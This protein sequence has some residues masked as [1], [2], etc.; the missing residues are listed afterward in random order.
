MPTFDHLF[1]SAHEGNNESIWEVN[2]DGWG[3]PIGAWNTFMFL[4]T[5]WK[6]FN[7]PSHNLV[8]AFINNGDTQRRASTITTDNVGWADNYWSSTNYPFA[9]KMRDT[10]GNQNFYIARL[11]DILLLKAEALASLGDVSGAMA[12]VN[13]V[14]TRAGIST[15]TATDQVEAINKVLEERLMELAFEGDRWF[16]LKRMG[17]AVEILSQQRDGNGV[18]IPTASNINQNRLLWPIPQDKLDANPLLTQNPGY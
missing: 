3:S 2:G 12:L 16:D 15:I 18:V 9:Y 14:R 4:G 1:D 13:Q 5:D 7:A 11:A 10:N 8:Q 6:K 17:K